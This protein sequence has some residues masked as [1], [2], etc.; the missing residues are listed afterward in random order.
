M[1]NNLNQSQI[2]IIDQL[3]YE[4]NR[5][6]REYNENIRSLIQLLN[7]QMP[8]QQMPRQQMSRQ[9][10]SRQQM[11]RQQMSRQQMS[12]TPTQDF[13][14]ESSPSSYSFNHIPSVDF[15]SYYIYPSHQ[16]PTQNL[17][18][19]ILSDDQINIGTE[20]IIFDVSMISLQ[21]E[22]NRCPIIMEPFLEGEELL[23]IKGCGHKF[24]KNALISWLHRS[25]QCPLCRYDVRD[26]CESI[27]LSM[28]NL[29]NHIH[30]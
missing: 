13:R 20:P 18:V 17:N 5:N 14:Q 8:R 25:S 29:S 7:Q 12:R 9:Q 26:Y 4:Y 22:D 15:L 16:P 1:N 23:K 21:V 6:M 30:P 10:M 2:T 24:K 19:P 3:M 11:P 27:D 28:N